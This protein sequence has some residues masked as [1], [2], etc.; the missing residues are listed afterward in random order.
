MTDLQLSIIVYIFRSPGRITGQFNSFVIER[1]FQDAHEEKTSIDWSFD[2]TFII[3]G[4]KDNSAKIYALKLLDNFHP[5]L[6][7][8]HHDDIVSCS[9][10]ENTLDTL[11]IG[12]NGQLSIWECSMKSDEMI[13]MTYVKEEPSEK[14]KKDEDK[15]VEEDD[16][17]DT[18]ETPEKVNFDETRDEQ[19]KLIIEKA[20]KR[21][22]HY[23]RSSRHFLMDELK[24][25]NRNCK[26]TAAHYHKKSKLLV[27]A[28]STGAFFLHE[29][30]DVTLIHSLN[31]SD[32][33]IDTV[34]F[35]NVGDWI[36][37]GVSGA[38]QLL[39]WEWQS[40]QYVMKQQGHSNAMSSVCYSSDGNFIITGGYDGKIKV[41]NVNSGFCTITF[42]D[43][44]SGV[45]GID[46]S[47]NKKFFVSASL[48]GTVRAFDMV[49]YRN[50]KTLTA[51]RLVQFSCVA[52][53]FSGDLVAAGAQDVFDIHLWSLKF[54]NLLE[55]ISGHE[56]PVVTLAFSPSPTSSML[57]SGAWDNHTRVWNCLDRSSDNEPIEMLHAT[58]CVAFKPNGEEIA[59]AS[60]NCTISFFD[61]A[62]NNQLGSIEC[63]NDVGLSM[64]DGDVVSAKK[65]LE[66]KYFTSITYSADGE[67]I[68]AGGK[69]KFV[70]IYHVREGV[71]LKKFEITQNLS[72]DG[73]SEFLNRRNLT[74]FGN[75]A[76]IEERDALEG[77]NVKINLPGTLKNDIASRNY[78]PEVGV[79]CL[80]FSPSGQQWTAATSEGLMI[81]SLD[82]GFIFDPYQ[83]SIEVTPKAARHFIKENE[84]SSALI[85]A[86]KLNEINLIQEIIEQIPHTDIDL[87]LDN[88]PNNFI[89]RTIDFIAKML[90]GHHIE[91]YLKWT[92]AALR[93]FG[94]KNETLDSQVLLT[95]QQNLS[96]KYDTLSKM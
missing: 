3:V 32:Y 4:S 21:P 69:S 5:V 14:R 34:T 38:G 74:D 39:V 15:D 44:T 61:A 92:H 87:V 81:Y 49:R 27:T 66:T 26:L 30:P 18:E 9:F 47:K 43:H 96:K 20:V 83:M 91:F 71:L 65:S 52:V 90:N 33:A 78:K 36:A 37:L 42:A 58:V 72:L 77:G 1:I 22:F 51:P 82:R 17:D 85:V 57:V 88:M 76:L 63:R 12:R 54:G 62:S 56:A 19:G 64:N 93:K 73:M 75:L 94:Q 10:L 35:N 11:M 6:L 89:H 13:E 70:C 68:L 84:Y 7:S 80:K 16:F 67:C 29:L 59:V 46:F 41:W 28:Y 55:V 25:E 40:E 2:S 79:S 23:K 8:G 48:D 53:D 86:L 50:F 45:T 60:L 95:L 31:I 24:K